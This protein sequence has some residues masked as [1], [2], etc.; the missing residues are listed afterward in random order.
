MKR[1][2]R[3]IISR[4]QKF[5]FYFCHTSPPLP[6]IRVQQREGMIQMKNYDVAV[7]GGGV[8]GLTAAIYAAKAGKQTVL[9]EKQECLDGRAITNKKQG[10]YFNLGGHAWRCLWNLPR[11]RL[12][13][14][15]T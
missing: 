6:V 15:R 14:V 2:I 3:T 9:L 4:K 12:E 8:A 7:I 1:G 5:F 11:I 10:A 13:L